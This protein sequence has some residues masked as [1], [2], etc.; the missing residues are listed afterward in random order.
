MRRPFGT[1][2]VR[3]CP[4]G[5]LLFFVPYFF[6]RLDFPSPAL[7][8]PGSPRMICHR[9]TA[10]SFALEFITFRSIMLRISDDIPLLIILH[11]FLIISLQDEE[12]GGFIIR[13]NVAGRP[14]SLFRFPPETLLKIQTYTTVR[15]DTKLIENEEMIV[16][17]NAIYAIA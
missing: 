14:V 2:L 11:V 1:G 8:A 13:Q 6:A 7:S 15:I 17:V 4:Q 16:A 10:N 5:L 9:I 12:I 3:H